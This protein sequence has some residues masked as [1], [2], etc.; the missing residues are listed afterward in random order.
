M[1]TAIKR[2]VFHRV[3]LCAVLAGLIGSGETP[4]KEGAG[5]GGEHL[6]LS[7]TAQ[8][9]ESG[10]VSLPSGLQYKILRPG[11]GRRP[12]ATDSVTV[13]YRGRLPDGTEIVSTY[14]KGDGPAVLRVHEL[15][16]GWRQALLLMQAGAKWEVFIPPKLA[17]L[18]RGTRRRALGGDRPVIYEIE[19]LAVGESDAPEVAMRSLSVGGADDT[20]ADAEPGRDDWVTRVYWMRGSGTGTGEVAPR[21]QRLAFFEQN[22]GKDSVITL[23]SGLQYRVLRRGTGR[24]PAAGDRVT[25]HYRG[26]RLDGTEFDSSHHGQGPV[27]FGLDQ[28][29]PGWQEA[30]QHMEEGAT[31]ELY[32]PPELAFRKPGP[33]GA[34]PVIFEVELLAVSRSDTAQVGIAAVQPIAAAGGPAAP[35]EDGRAAPLDAGTGPLGAGRALSGEAT[36]DGGVIRLPSGV[37]YRVI[38]N[39]TGVSPMAD[40]RIAVQYRVALLGGHETGAYAGEGRTSFRLDQT[41]PAWQA[42]FQRMQEGARWEVSLPSE[43][44]YSKWGP[45]DGETVVFDVELLT[46]TAPD[47]AG[48]DAAVKQGLAKAVAADEPPVGAKAGESPLARLPGGVQYRVLEQGSG[49]TPAADDTITVRYRAALLDGGAADSAYTVEGRETFRLDWAIPGWQEAFERMQAGAKWAL[50]MPSEFAYSKWGPLG[51][52]TMRF[53]V[54]LLSLGVP[55]AL[56][57]A[58]ASEQGVE[59]TRAAAE[60]SGRMEQRQPVPV[61]VQPEAAAPQGEARPRMPPGARAAERAFFEQ[62]AENEGVISL[63]SGLQYRVLE[64]GSGRSPQATDRVLVQYRGRLI[65]GREVDS[66]YVQAGA[67]E[68]RVDEVMAGWREALQLMQE[69]AR[70]ELYIPSRLAHTQG[71]RK[72]GMFG[73]QPLI[74]E[75]ELLAVVE[76]NPSSAGM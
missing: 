65:N 25:V 52:G 8:E 45:G 17:R 6:M 57:L 5:V 26:T 35:R 74:Y 64:A 28:V 12:Q 44:A 24:T 4:A 49:D 50:Y 21:A 10:V 47:T 38:R 15:A 72:R 60:P 18:T 73:I 69:G 2:P 14:Q 30:L 1:A 29:I 46:V 22:A 27:T 20:E 61:D 3:L 63:P 56:D 59:D 68:V 34:E 51:G 23:P 62:N 11:T 53:E 71:T 75:I 41:I 55:E 36:R 32:V 7:D 31:W 43:L 70:W 58:M 9:Q 19:L 76:P 67:A 39:G 48:T 42:V 16:A 54:E 33:L 37:H 66:S 40:D 13:H